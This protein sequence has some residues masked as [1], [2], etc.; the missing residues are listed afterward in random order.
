MQQTAFAYEVVIGED[1]STDGTRAIVAEYQKRYPD[2]IRAF[3]REKNLGAYEN[4][5]TV[6]AAARG[7]FVALLDGDDYWTDSLKLQKQVGFLESHPAY[8]GSCHQTRGVAAMD[9]TL[10]QLY[11][12]FHKLDLELVDAIAVYAPWQTSSFVYRRSLM[13]IPDWYD[14]GGD[15]ALFIIIASQGLIRCFPEVMSVYRRHAGGLS[16]SSELSDTRVRRH[17]EMLDH[18]DEYLEGRCHNKIERVRAYYRR[19]LLD[20][21]I[22]EGD[23][24]SASG[25]ARKLLDYGLRHYLKDTRWMLS[26][27][28]RGNCPRLWQILR[29]LK[30]ERPT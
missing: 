9:G 7:E 17:I 11:G 23:Y 2:R 27:I 12:Q 14:I 5:L 10:S 22:Q 25:Q 19:E 6:L 20:K 29:G 18:F 26:I 3:L 15:V 30:G 16:A 4:S 24:P 21:L 1:C 28:F 8:S 13:N